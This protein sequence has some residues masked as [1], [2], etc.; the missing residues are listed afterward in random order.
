MRSNNGST[1]SRVSMERCASN[2]SSSEV[3][4]MPNASEKRIA[5]PPSVR[6][7]LRWTAGALKATSLNHL[8]VL[9]GKSPARSRRHCQQARDTLRY[10]KQMTEVTHGGTSTRCVD[11]ARHSPLLL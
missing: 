9:Y 10:S 7:R 6:V 11:A 8:W 2:Q 1:K 4:A 3:L 5:G